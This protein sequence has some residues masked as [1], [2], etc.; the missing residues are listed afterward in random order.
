MSVY[1]FASR[2]EPMSGPS[3]GRV[4]VQ[5]RATSTLTSLTDIGAA[6]LLLDQA[7]VLATPIKLDVSSSSTAD[8]AA[9]TGAQ[10]I[11][12]IGLGASKNYQTEVLVPTGTTIKASA[13]TW[14]R[15]FAAYVS[16]AGTGL[17]NTGDIYMVATGLG[18]TY[19]TPGVPGTFDITSAI[20]KML[21][22]S[23][24]MGTA[25][26]TTPSRLGYFWQ[27]DR[28]KISTK[29]LTT[30]GLVVLQVR[31]TSVA[32]NP[33]VNEKV[34]GLGTGGQTVDIDLSEAQLIYGPN[35]DIRLLCSTG[36]AAGYVTA[37]MHIKKIG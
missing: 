10:A 31:D 21:A 25:F 24:N 5:G 35:T 28:V 12:I 29:A 36:T 27:V 32:T 16:K 11:T 37:E 1:T 3:N 34:I 2:Y 20:G 15:V 26:Y 19:S 9:G 23:S 30:G 4:I 33:Y 17:T 8:A 18:G 7:G 13:K 6:N 14:S 22:S